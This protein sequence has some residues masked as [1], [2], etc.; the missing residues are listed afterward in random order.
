M[1]SNNRD[2]QTD[3]NRVKRDETYLFINKNFQESIIEY[4]QFLRREAILCDVTL[5]LGSQRFSCHRNVL[6]VASPY[7]RALFIDNET[8]KFIKNVELPRDFC[9]SIVEALLAYMYGGKIFISINNVIEI[10]KGAN[11]FKLRSL[12]E[13][14]SHVLVKFL[15]PEN[16]LEIQEISLT[17]GHERL[18][19]RSQRFVYENFEIVA[20]TPQ[21][22]ELAQCDLETLLSSNDIH[23]TSEVEVRWSLFFPQ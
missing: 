5:R 13:E 23:A 20:H 19:Q 15:T 3:L 10:F 17:Y 8:G 9:Y 12:L 1:P 7:F 14:C 2:I 16:C 11:F 22:L 4:F 6:G 18:Y 21:F